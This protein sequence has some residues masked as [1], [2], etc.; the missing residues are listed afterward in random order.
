MALTRIAPHDT[1]AP[2]RIAVEQHAGL[3]VI[4]I[5]LALLWLSVASGEFPVNDDW[6]FAHSVRWLIDEHRIRL[7]DWS[8]MNLLPQTLLGA[9]AVELFAFSF[10]T[11]RHLTQLV[12]VVVALALFHWFVAAGLA[13]RESLVASLVVIAMPCWPALSS[14]FM[15]DLYGMLFALPA[16]T[17]FL[18]AL[19]APLARTLIAATLLT[20][21]GVL[22]R[23]V[24]LVVPAAFCVAW[25]AT[26]P[27]WRPRAL[28]IGV[29][30]IAVAIGVELAYRTY[31][32]LGPGIPE[33]Q[34]YLHGRVVPAIYAMLINKDRYAVWVASNVAT[35]A[36]YLGLF[37]AP[38]ALWRGALTRGHERWALLGTAALALFMLATDWLPPFRAHNMLDAAGIG[39]QLLYDAV[40]GTPASLD[41]SAGVLWRGA[42]IA[43]A[44]GTT[45]LVVATARSAR[46]IVTNAAG[47][48]GEWLYPAALV[49]AYMLP[50]ALT[51]YFD[52]YLLFVLPFAIVLIARCWSGQDNLARLVAGCWL[53]LAVGLG[54]AATHDYFAWNRA[55][56]QAIHA[57]EKLGATADSLDG[58]FEYNGYYRFEIKPRV[59][60]GAGKSWWWVADDRYVVAFSA[61][62][63]FVERARFD[64]D[65]WLSRTP[66]VIFLL[67]RAP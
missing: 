48:Q 58:G 39:P 46:A 22:E 64:V 17:L 57:A 12:S 28:A 4:G 6:A 65:R 45:V 36:A 30:P 21:A 42:A 63:G 32:A 16:A 60:G 1:R 2:L 51:D 61:P 14:S 13:R 29:A 24:V 37:V 38:W 27:S 10:V 44:Y 9:G 33:A 7:S 11:L 19:R 66:P 35:L 20:A 5:Q 26:H 55:R 52:R 41:R 8:A 18:H 67:E 23:Q 25:F 3:I 54:V 43:S 56:W 50:L 53:V 15:T 59:T 49:G 31:L 34:Q 62:S 40:P 47:D